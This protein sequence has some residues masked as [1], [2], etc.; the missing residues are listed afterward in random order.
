MVYIDETSILF[1]IHVPHGIH[2]RTPRLNLVQQKDTCLKS[3]GNWFKSL[4]VRWENSTNP[5]EIN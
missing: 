5:K 1:L 3:L 2:K 4:K